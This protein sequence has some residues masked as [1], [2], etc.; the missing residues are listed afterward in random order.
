MRELE[1]QVP[2]PDLI[3]VSKWHWSGVSYEPVEAG[4][5]QTNST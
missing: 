5:G 3:G 1:L 4:L 2:T